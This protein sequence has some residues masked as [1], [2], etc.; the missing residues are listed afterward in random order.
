GYRGKSRSWP[1][2]VAAD[3]DPVEVGDEAV[4]MARRCDCPVYAAP[5]R[6]VAAGQLLA[7]TDVDV[8]LADDGL[9]HYA[10]AR[11]IEV[12]VIDDARGFGNGFML[13][14]GPLRESGCR[15]EDVD[16]V[17]HHGGEGVHP[18]WMRLDITQ[19]LSLDGSTQVK[20]L[21]EF[22]GQSVHAIA[23]IGNPA[24]FFDRLREL[25]LDVVEHAF[26]DHHDYIEQD[27]LF[28]DGAAL[29]M[30]E[31]DA[32]KVAALRL[33][34]SWMVRADT[35]ASDSIVEQVIDGIRRTNKV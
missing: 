31:K 22:V 28:A 30:T 7:E 9:Q 17:V 16:V 8:I 4:L 29:L 14:A 18:H 34:N 11:D 23:G 3:S 12:A 10:L 13:P 15:L 19:A 32:V 6:V 5:D 1:R 35:V 20:S 24:R 27:F 25:G 2:R 21:S 33:T 26:P